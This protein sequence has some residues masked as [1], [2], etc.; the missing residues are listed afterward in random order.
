MDDAGL[1]PVPAKGQCVLTSSCFSSNTV[2]QST[3]PILPCHAASSVS[4]TR[5]SL[6]IL[7]FPMPVPVRRIPGSDHPLP[8]QYSMYSLP[9]ISESCRAGTRQ[10]EI[11]FPKRAAALRLTGPE[12]K[13][14]QESAF[15]VSRASRSSTWRAPCRFS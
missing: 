8:K 9:I 13:E 7:G 3:L 1:F 15:H 11:L 2:L 12:D 5:Y 4:L 14:V 10:D 6:H